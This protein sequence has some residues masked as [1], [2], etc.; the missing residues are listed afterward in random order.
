MAK[1]KKKKRPSE[2]LRAWL[3]CS[4]TAIQINSL[5]LLVFKQAE[6]SICSSR[7]EKEAAKFIPNYD[8]FI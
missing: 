1:K 7:G 5:V 8:D 4:L 2:G 3:G 6:F